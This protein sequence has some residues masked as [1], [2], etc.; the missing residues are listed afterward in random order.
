[1]M[2]RSDPCEG[3][4]K[5]EL[6]WRV[7]DC[8]AVLRKF[9]LVI[10]RVIEPKSCIGRVVCLSEISLHYYY[11]YAWSLARKSPGRVVFISK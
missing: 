2:C 5:E 8:N 1:M 6:V 4:G 3:E 7:S 11:H 10:Y 9:L